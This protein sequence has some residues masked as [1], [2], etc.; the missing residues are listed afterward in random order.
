MRVWNKKHKP[1]HWTKPKWKT[2]AL[3]TST[4][5]NY[6]LVTR[7][8][9]DKDKSKDLFGKFLNNKP[10]YIFLSRSRKKNRKSMIILAGQ[11]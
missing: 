2:R 1:K 9:K 10:K 4:I 3:K 11:K 5:I 7:G 8:I 6:C